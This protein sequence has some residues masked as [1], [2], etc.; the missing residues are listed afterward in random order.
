MFADFRPPFFSRQQSFYSIFGLSNIRTSILS[1]WNVTMT[2]P[3]P[4]TSKS[5]IF[6]ATPDKWT[7]SFG[8]KPSEIETF[9]PNK[10]PM[11]ND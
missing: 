2:K 10:N 8:Y 5:I 11:E 7:S 6:A 1:D 4:L 9:Q 3:M